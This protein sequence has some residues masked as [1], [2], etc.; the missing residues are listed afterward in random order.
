MFNNVP[1]VVPLNNVTP[2]VIQLPLRGFPKKNPETMIPTQQLRQI[3]F[4]FS[5]AHSTNLLLLLTEERQRHNCS[6]HIESCPMLPASLTAAERTFDRVG[7]GD[8][9]I[10]TAYDGEIVRDT[11]F[12]DGLEASLFCFE[13]ARLSQLHY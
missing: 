4:P 6:L 5:V 9:L 1:G 2:R 11:V 7:L 10:A 12:I 3:G 8:Y 13:R